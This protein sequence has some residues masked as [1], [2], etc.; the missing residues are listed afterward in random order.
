MSENIYSAQEQYET[1]IAMFYDSLGSNTTFTDTGR[2][3]LLQRGQ[4]GFLMKNNDEI[5]VKINPGCND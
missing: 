4:K 5:K 1:T 3:A 2:R